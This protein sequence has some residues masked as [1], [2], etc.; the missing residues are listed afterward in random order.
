MEVPI[1]HPEYDWFGDLGLKWHALPAISDWR[2][3]IGGISYSCAPFSGWYMSAEIGARNLGDVGRYN[4]L[5]AI[6]QRMG[7]NTRSKIS[8]WQDRALIELNRAV[9]HSYGSPGYS[10]ISEAYMTPGMSFNTCT[11][12]I[13]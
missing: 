13:L 9:L 8:L 4:L 11:G 7:L 2:L 6:A 5:P 10:V 1:V 3:E 12:R